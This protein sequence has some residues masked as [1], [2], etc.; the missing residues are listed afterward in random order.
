MNFY[1]FGLQRSGTNF[2]YD[3]IHGNFENMLQLNIVDHNVSSP[4]WKHLIEPRNEWVPNVPVLFVYKNPYTWLESV[5]YRNSMDFWE[6]HGQ[7]GR[8]SPIVPYYVDTNRK[9]MVYSFEHA[10]RMWCHA[11]HS[12]AIDPPFPT[13]PI[14]YEDLLVEESRDK[15][16]AELKDKY[17]LT[18]TPNAGF[19][20]AAGQV[21][22]SN[23]YT[24]SMGDYYKEGRPEN[25]SKHF[26]EM[27]GELLDEDILNFTEYEKI[28]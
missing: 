1:M 10:V 20:P 11:I 4:T 15:I 23:S 21:I 18:P 26:I 24:P 9:V 25:L 17:N 16:F 8:Q 5:A 27:V 14:K 6:S 22:N 13:F 2:I 12:W 3:T 28:G 19:V 7:E